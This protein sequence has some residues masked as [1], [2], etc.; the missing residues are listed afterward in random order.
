M[1]TGK[2]SHWKEIPAPNMGG[3][4]G[5]GGMQ[6]PPGMPQ[7]RMPGSAGMKPDGSGPLWGHPQRNGSWADGPG[8]P[9]DGPGGWSDE[10]PGKMGGGWNDQALL[11][12]GGQGSWGGPKP[13]NPMGQGSWG[14]GS[15]V[16]PSSWGHP[17]PVSI[18][19]MSA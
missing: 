18:D 6:C 8:G 13:K 19:I 1:I 3:R 11:G 10:G 5:A 4:G 7:G 17:K 16:D 2:V 14:D 15:E 9:H 12:G